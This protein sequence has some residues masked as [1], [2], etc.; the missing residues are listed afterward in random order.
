[1][2]RFIS[3]CPD[4]QINI[5]NIWTAAKDLLNKYF[6]YKS[7]APS[8]QYIPS[9]VEFSNGWKRSHGPNSVL[10]LSQEITL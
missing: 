8:Q 6:A 1:M 7:G 5:S 4:K 3:L 9:F 2:N 10:Q